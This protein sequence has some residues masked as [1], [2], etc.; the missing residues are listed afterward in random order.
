[1]RR[2]RSDGA[3]TAHRYSMPQAS[4]SG[5][6]RRTIAPQFACRARRSPLKWK[7]ARQSRHRSHSPGGASSWHTP[8]VVAV[9]PFTLASCSVACVGDA[10]ARCA[11]APARPAAHRARYRH[12]YRKEGSC[13]RQTA[14]LKTARRSRRGRSPFPRCRFAGSGDTGGYSRCTPTMLTARPRHR[15]RRTPRF[16]RQAQLSWKLTSAA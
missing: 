3:H 15:R 11:A 14:A 13:R 12:A 6:R 16:E 9:P 1:M 10:P 7:R 5:C 8:H 2:P 4:P